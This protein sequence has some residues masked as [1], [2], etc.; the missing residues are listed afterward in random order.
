MIP[1]SPW[2]EEKTNK[3]KELLT[4]QP[5]IS[6]EAIAR[7]L[8]VTRNAVIG[9]AHRMKLN[10]PAPRSPGKYQTKQRVS[11]KLPLARHQPPILPAPSNN[12]KSPILPLRLPSGAYIGMQDI[13]PHQCR[14]P[15]GD[16]LK[17][18]FHFCGRETKTRNL[19]WC[20]GH[21]E[22]LFLKEQPK[23]LERLANLG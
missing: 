2:T 13:G 17:P 5:V 10:K 1:Q 20:V 16:P 4:A 18:D 12:K 14:W 22:K 6:F 15:Y 7:Y 8:G 19:S 21:L 23:K 11:K 9:K 3:L